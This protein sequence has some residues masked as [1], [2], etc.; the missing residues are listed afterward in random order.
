M[1]LTDIFE[2]HQ[3]LLDADIAL[4]HYSSS[5]HA[6]TFAFAMTDFYL[7]QALSNPNVSAV[8]TLSELAG[9]IESL[10]GVVVS[11]NPK[12][13][14]FNCH[15]KMFDCGLFALVKE[16]CISER[17]VISPTAVIKNHVIIEDDVIID[18]YAVIESNSILRRGV[19]V[20]THAVV[21]AR[22]M[23]DTFIDG[24]RIWVKDA[25][26]V[27]LEEGVQVLSHA[28]VQK[29]YFYEATTIGK[30][31]IVS[32]Q[33]NIGHGCQIGEKTL[34]AGNA[35]LAGYVTVGNNVW[36]GPSVTI[37][38]GLQIAD[39]AEILLGSVVVNNIA[40]QQR[41]SGNFAMSHTKNIRKFTR[42]SR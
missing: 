5:L 2:S 32:V 11:E 1:K 17:A 41:V 16:T 22:G 18:D 40:M 39:S 30:Y 28:T 6:K 38:H 33:C 35:Q 4:T 24:E 27:I 34:I 36:I 7:S 3:V 8:I 23:H 21:G 25:G 26:G 13:S 14:F 31:S 12:R 15:N 37:A 29:S 42:E 20:G 10:K 9:R 19:Y